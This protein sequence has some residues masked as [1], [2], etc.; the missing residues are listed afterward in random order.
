MVVDLTDYR[1][2]SAIK[3]PEDSPTDAVS[4]LVSRTASAGFLQIIQISSSKASVQI[5]NGPALEPEKTVIGPDGDLPDLLNNRGAA[6]LDD[7][8]FKT[9]SSELGTGPFASLSDLAAYLA[10]NPERRVALVGHTD[11]VGSLDGN[12]ALSKRRATSVMERLIAD[13]S[14]AAAQLSAQGVGYLAPRASNL[15]PDGR[16]ANRRV[17][18]VLSSTK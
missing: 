16:E 8:I 9:G 11:A 7:L 3:G 5:Q 14:T 10:Q 4:L 15:S 13:Y 18:A 6:V 1:F 2:I 12:I 17:E